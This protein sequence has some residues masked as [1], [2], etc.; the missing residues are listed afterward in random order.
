MVIKILIK[1]S[2]IRIREIHNIIITNLIKLMV[3]IMLSV[4]IVCATHVKMASMCYA[5]LIET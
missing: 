2:I 5:L 4:N 1:Y 3:R